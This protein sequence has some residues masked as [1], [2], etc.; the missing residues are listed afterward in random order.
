MTVMCCD[1]AA[2][3]GQEH[4]FGKDISKWDCPQSTMG[5][6]KTYFEIYISD[7]EKSNCIYQGYTCLTCRN[8][9]ILNEMR[10][11][12]D[13]VFHGSLLHVLELLL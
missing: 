7:F 13:F 1:D 6:M 5:A 4:V 2:M 12:V 9:K 11:F 8:F 10:N 3:L